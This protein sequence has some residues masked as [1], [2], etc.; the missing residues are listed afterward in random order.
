MLWRYVCLYKIKRYSFFTYLLY[1]QAQN[2]MDANTDISAL[3]EDLIACKLREAEA[4]MAIKE[5]QHQLFEVEKHWQVGT[6][7]ILSIARG[8]RL[9]VCWSIEQM[10]GWSEH[11][12]Q[13]VATSTV[14]SREALAGWDMEDLVWGIGLL[15]GGTGC[16]RVGP[17]SKWG[18]SN[19]GVATST[20]RSGKALAGWDM[21]DLV[22][23]LVYCEGGQVACGWS[24]EQVGGEAIKELQHQLFEVEKHWQL[25]RGGPCLG[26]RSIEIMGGTG[27]MQ[28]GSSKEWGTGWPIEI[29]GDCLNGLV[30]WDNGGNGLHVGWFIKRVGASCMWVGPLRERGE[31]T[32]PWSCFYFRYA[33]KAL[34]IYFESII[35]IHVS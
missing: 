9:H 2:E 8:D 28:V 32:A 33:C 14:L 18:W 11:D 4:N 29:M 23:G 31:W 5:L 10:G 30:Y 27:C 35:V 17:S 16:M 34:S 24:I 6:G 3:H 7:R 19:Q 12:D 22:W 20:V 15:Q 21:E 1:W 26:D 13:G 25:R